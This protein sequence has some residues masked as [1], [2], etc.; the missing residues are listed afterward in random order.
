[1]F[2]AALTRRLPSMSAGLGRSVSVAGSAGNTSVS[3]RPATGFCCSET[4]PVPALE[5]LAIWLRSVSE[6]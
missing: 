3:D 2:T 6:T 5:I 1:M 4:V